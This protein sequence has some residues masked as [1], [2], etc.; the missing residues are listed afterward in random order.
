M[1]VF[2]KLELGTFISM[3]VCTLGS[4]IFLMI[5]PPLCYFFILGNIIS[6]MV[7][8]SKLNKL[9]VEGFPEEFTVYIERIE[10]VYSNADDYMNE[11]GTIDFE[12]EMA[13]LSAKESWLSGNARLRA[14]RFAEQREERDARREKRRA[15]RAEQHARHQAEKYDRTAAV[16]RARRD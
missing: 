5:F 3:V 1:T 12:A 15:E 7:L 4:T 14:K 9:D 16:R 6:E 8:R 2:Y 11:D 10:E 13:V